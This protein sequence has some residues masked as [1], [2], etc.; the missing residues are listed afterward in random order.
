M[1]ATFPTD[2]IA[3]LRHLTLADIERRLADLNAER[4]AL[5]TIRRALA[6]RERARRRAAARPTTHEG[7]GVPGA[8]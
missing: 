7:K 3:A 5:T 2:P 1:A 6:A 8:S 4:S